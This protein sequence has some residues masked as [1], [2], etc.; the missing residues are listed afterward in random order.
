MGSEKIRVGIIGA[1]G[2]AQYGHIPVLKSLTEFEITALASRDLKTAQDLA[3]SFQIRHAFDDEASLL[4]HPEVDLVAVL[5]PGPEHYRLTKAAIAAGK[6]VYCEWPLSTRTDLS[7]E[8][9]ALANE[10]H[11]RHVVGLQRRFGP[12]ARYLQD[13]IRQGYVGQVRG[14]RMALGLDAF[15]PV[16]S[17]KHAWTFD[18]AN[19]TNVLT[20]YAAHFQDLLFHA[21]GFPRKLTAVVETQFPMITVVETGAQVPNANPHE[22]MVIGTLEGGGLFSIQIEG[23]QKH[24]TGVMI[25]ITGTEGVLRV[26]NPRGFQNVGDNRIDGMRDGHD[27]APLPV[28]AAYHSL[29]NPGLDVSVHDLAYLYAAYAH[30]R[31]H[32]TST[33]PNFH[34]AL[35]QHRLIDQ[36]LATSATFFA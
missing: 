32:G 23:A 27:M 34:D 7:E 20:I 17:E 15:P 21:V 3:S 31:R 2:W 10:N 6:D 35:R 22:V 5:A 1:G 36:I 28:P 11:V 13:L 25:E 16:M 14:V 8:L 19:F 4:T 18:P 30:D 9:M 33:A 26:T 24:R 29:P 12:S